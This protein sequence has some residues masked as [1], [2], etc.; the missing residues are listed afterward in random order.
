MSHRRIA[1]IVA[2]FLLTAVAAPAVSAA[3]VPSVAGMVI[4]PSTSSFEETWDAVIETLEANPNIGIVA[5]VDHAAAAAAAGLDLA[6]TREVF[7]GNPA[8]GSPLMAI[9]QT[10]GIDLPQKILVWEEE[11][12]AVFIG[13]NSTRYLAARHGVGS[14]ATLPV[15][16]AALAGTASSASGVSVVDRSSARP[17]AVDP[18]LVQLVSDA[19]V[20]ATF[21]R[22]LA[23]IDAAPPSVVFTLDHSA[24]AATAGVDLPETRLIVFG[25]P[26]LGTPLMQESQTIGL[27]LP[28]KFLVYDRDGTTYVAYNDVHALARRHG[29]TGQAALLDGIASALAGLAAAGAG[30]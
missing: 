14:A 7:F 15:I 8:L 2:V 28:L 1:T 17:Y 5:T 25:S 23:A 3:P 30:S 11:N 13:Y 16:A 24:N 22:L 18:R 10:A 21:D 6:P 12:G 20:A 9:N 29:I 26:V 4:T 19:D 27:D